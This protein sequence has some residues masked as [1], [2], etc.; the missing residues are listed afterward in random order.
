MKHYDAIVIGAGQ[1]GSPLCRKLANAGKKTLM[2]EKRWIGGTCVND[3]CTP[4]KAMVASAKAAYLAKRCTD[5]GV[6]IDGYH[7]DMKQVKK[8]KDE[9]VLQSRNGGQKAIEKTENLDLL[10]GEAS[11]TGSKTI[12]VKLNDGGE[13]E[14]KADLIFLD[15]GA[16]PVIPEID[17]LKDIDYL[18]STSIL[19]LE[20]VPKHILIIGG[21]YVALE[22]AQMFHRFGSKISV[23][24][25]GERIMAKEDQ[26]VSDELK[27][28]L[29]DE[30]LD[31]YTKA[32]VHHF[33]KTVDGIKA[34]AIIGGEKKEFICSHVLLAAGRKPLTE[35]LQL[36][37]TG[38]ELNEKGFIKVDNKLETNVPGIYALGDVNG[39]P[40]FT[41]IA[42]N[43]YT[44]V[45]RN[46]IEGTNYNTTDRPLPY[47]MFTDPQLG[48]VG[49]TEK[50]AREQGYDIKVATLPMKHVARAIEVG[51]TRG[52]MKAVVN[53]K[54]KEI[55]G[56][57][58]L[59]E[60]GGEIM[61][62][63]QMAMEGG[64]TYDRIR[65][66]VFAHPTYSESLNNLFMKI[67]E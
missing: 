56:A 66:C 29:V 3:G 64:I 39:G 24:E 27:K 20:E 48:R 11:F 44:I 41:H 21:N 12:K 59:A 40:A 33:E 46:L 62:V 26:D 49:L 50:Q 1:A 35:A 51:D 8:R 65:Y 15:A 45:Y 43:D 9:I 38:V 2:I 31:I 16:T 10:F 37:K 18:T 63:L 5:L 67:E 25:R 57:A 52:M 28:I 60:E 58:V 7:I 22:F 4:T 53:A 36:D 61:S 14:V 17:G 23:L 54:T 19:D 42:Y 47:C 55:L 13:E 30:G 6:T 32:E 34:S